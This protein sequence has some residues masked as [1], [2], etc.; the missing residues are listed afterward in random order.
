MLAQGQNVKELDLNSLMACMSGQ[1]VRELEF[2][3]LK[4]SIS[5]LYS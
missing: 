5:I 1:N 2:N 4:A 3:F